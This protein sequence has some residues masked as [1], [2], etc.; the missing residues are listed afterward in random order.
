MAYKYARKFIPYSRDNLP[1]RVPK[2]VYECEQLQGLSKQARL[3]L[4]WLIYYYKHGKN[5]S[6]TS[7]Y[8]GISR[9]TF[10]ISQT[11]WQI[12]PAKRHVG[13]ACFVAE[14]EVAV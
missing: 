8:Y 11:T 10:Y 14:V 5:A 12:R 4:K 7:R 2:I 6:L 3:R 13:Q 1:E 9:K